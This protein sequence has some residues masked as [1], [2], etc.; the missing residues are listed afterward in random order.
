MTMSEYPAV[1]TIDQILDQREKLYGRFPTV[2]AVSQEISKAMRT[3]NW[4][5]LPAYQRES[6]ELIANKMAR[7]VASGNASYEDS[8]VDISGYA[9]LV[10]RE[11]R[12]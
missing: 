8:W 2:A 4:S 3:Q 7:I 6:L 11:I 1:M 12:R 5:Q 9:E 10:L